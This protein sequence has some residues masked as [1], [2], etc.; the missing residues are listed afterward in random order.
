MKKIGQILKRQDLT[1][2]QVILARRVAESAKHAIEDFK[3][4]H[5]NGCT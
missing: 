3:F 4:K 1:Y 5:E 2:N